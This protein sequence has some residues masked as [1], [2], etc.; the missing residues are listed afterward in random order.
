M[1]CLFSPLLLAINSLRK[2]PI[3]TIF[4][5]RFYGNISVAKQQK[6]NGIWRLFHVI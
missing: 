2:W 3:S 5:M 1:N 4:K 6:A